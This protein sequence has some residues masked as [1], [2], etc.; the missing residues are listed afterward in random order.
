MNA[1]RFYF[2]DLP[3]YGYA[4]AGREDRRQWAALVD[5]YI[6]NALPHTQVVMLVD[7]KVG[8]TPLDEQAYSYLASLGAAAVVAVTK[9]DNVKRGRRAAAVRGIREVLKLP[10]STPVIP[11]SAH[12]GEGIK[13]L[14]GTITRH[15]E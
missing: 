13:E 7:G 3:G 8:A 4:K 12:S 5:D 15:L 11:V 9:I 6:R 2:V 1:R 10:E 14:W